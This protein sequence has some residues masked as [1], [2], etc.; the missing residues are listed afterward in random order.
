MPPDNHIRLG[1]YSSNAPNSRSKWVPYGA[2][3][4]FIT[5]L[6]AALANPAPV[7]TIVRARVAA[8]MGPEFDGETDEWIFTVCTFN[9]AVAGLTDDEMT[10]LRAELIS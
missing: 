8:L 9:P 5:Q 7:K 2:V 10:T 4:G 1:V 3:M 6:K